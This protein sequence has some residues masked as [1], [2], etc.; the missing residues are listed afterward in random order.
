MNPQN[1]NEPMTKALAEEMAKFEAAD[2]IEDVPREDIE[3]G[4]VAISPMDLIPKRTPNK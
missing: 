1:L 2:L 3:K 4:L